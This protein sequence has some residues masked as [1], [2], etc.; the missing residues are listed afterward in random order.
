MSEDRDLEGD[1]IQMSTC[2]QVP[3]YKTELEHSRLHAD[4]LAPSVVCRALKYSA[5]GGGDYADELQVR[6]GEVSNSAQLQADRSGRGREHRRT[7][8]NGHHDMFLLNRS[9][10]KSLCLKSQGLVLV[11]W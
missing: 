11:H 4:G 3:G 8:T 10:S 6:A 1:K 9:L 5:A 2:R 7:G